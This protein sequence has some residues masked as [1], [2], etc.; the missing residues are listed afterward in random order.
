[1]DSSVD[2]DKSQNLKMQQIKDENMVT[3]AERGNFGQDLQQKSGSFQFGPFAPVSVAKTGNPEDNVTRIYDWEGL[4]STFRPQ[5]H[6]Q[7]TI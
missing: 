5:Y 3:V 7:G 4:S 1:M 6:N 2:G